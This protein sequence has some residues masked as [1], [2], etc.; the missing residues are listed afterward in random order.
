MMLLAVFAGLALL[1][2]AIG[3]YGVMSYSVAQRRKEIGVRMALGAQPAQVSRMV[4]REGMALVLFGAVFGLAG[5]LTL[6]RVMSNLLY[7]VSSFDPGT[8]LA[9]SGLLGLTAWL[10]C[11]LAARRATRVDP[12][13]AL[14]QG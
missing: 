4:V 7:G 13:V 2:A 12:M 14:R 11:A 10:A 8:W 5:A 6:S 3:L 9:V 1:L